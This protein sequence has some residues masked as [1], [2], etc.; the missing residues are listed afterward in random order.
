MYCP[1][2][3]HQNLPGSDA[4]EKC[5]LPLTQLDGATP[6][7]RLERSL[8]TDPVSVLNPRAPVTV[9]V[10]ATLADAMARMIEL[11]V[12]A[13]LV[14]DG[15]GKLVGILTER[16]FLLK[17]AG[18]PGFEALPVEQ[19]MTPGPETVAP[20]DTLAFALGKMDSGGYRHL[21]VVETGR[22]VA[23]SGRLIARNG[24]TPACPNV[25]PR[26]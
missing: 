24:V 16:D 23:V 12:G 19:F 17:I 25:P 4:C 3:V 10:S 1:A 8:V 6:H 26:K 13:V 15:A 22:P 20:T 18:Q 9:L 5:G 7:D 14:T 11:S 21:P 2:C